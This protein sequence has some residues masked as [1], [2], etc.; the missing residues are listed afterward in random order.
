MFDLCDSWLNIR[1]IEIEVYANND[2]ALCLYR[3]F[4]FKEEGYFKDFAFR[5]GGMLMPL[6][7]LVLL[8]NLNWG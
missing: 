4:G 1:R 3:K 7:W 6:H 5:Q 2:A 8:V